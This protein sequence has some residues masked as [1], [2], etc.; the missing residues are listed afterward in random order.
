MSPDI[1]SD[2]SDD[3][4]NFITIFPPDLLQDAWRFYER[5]VAV[6]RTLERRERERQ[7]DEEEERAD[8]LE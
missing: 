8:S 7:E 1:G 5:G 2:V 4:L 3:T 6:G